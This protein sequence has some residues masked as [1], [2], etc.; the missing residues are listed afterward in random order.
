ML[1][2]QVPAHEKPGKCSAKMGL[3]RGRRAGGPGDPRG[4]DAHR[5]SPR[6]GPGCD[7]LMQRA[8]F[9]EGPSC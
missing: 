1:S 8:H 7:S 9:Q 6:P 2:P 3:S 5:P 4:Q